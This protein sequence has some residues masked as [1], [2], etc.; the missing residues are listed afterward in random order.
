MAPDLADGPVTRGPQPFAQVR[1]IPYRSARCPPRSGNAPRGADRRGAGS[2][3]FR[4]YG[5]RRTPPPAAE[6]RAT[7]GGSALVFAELAKRAPVWQA[8]LRGWNVRTSRIVEEWREEGREEG[9]LA[10]ARENLYG[11]L[12]ERFGRVPKAWE[13]RIQAA[14]DLDR[15]KEALRRVVHIQTLDELQL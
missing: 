14:T 3:R 13:R 2:W 7:L 10:M 15:L 12:V 4:S 1:S 8:G 6:A 5:A 11:L 9:R